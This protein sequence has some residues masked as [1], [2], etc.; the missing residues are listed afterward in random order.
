MKKILI[1]GAG[2][3]GKKVVD[4]NLLYS[5]TNQILAIIDNNPRLT[6]YNGIAI[7]SPQEISNYVYDEIWICT[8]YYEEIREQLIK[9]HGVNEEMIVYIE[10]VIHIL[11]ERI[12]EK[13]GN[14]KNCDI[15]EEL[16]SVV[17]Y[18][19]KNHA[20]MYCYPFYDEYIHNNP[21]VVFDKDKGMYYTLYKSKKMYFSKRL[22]TEQKVKTYFNSIVMEQDAKSPHCYWHNCMKAEMGVYVD[23]GAAE[24]IFS[25]DIIEKAAHV[26]IIEVD[27][28]W[29]EALKCT[30]KPFEEKVTIVS[31]YISDTDGENYSKLD[32]VFEKEKIDYIK[33]DI[34]GMEFPALKGACELLHR[35]D[36]KM[37]ICVYHHKDD[38]SKINAWLLKHDYK[39]ENSKGY[40]L[41][42]GD[43][44]LELNE[45]DFR[46]GLLYAHKM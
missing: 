46:R 37:A 27:E 42:Q 5:K 30:F 2:E 35:C 38:N 10:P 20:H 43:W 9:E 12:R 3:R 21:M 40:V 13:Y 1:F 26:Y 19:N 25:L 18:V 36:V 6:C 23:V 29:I 15:S 14:I 34:E 45:T 32:T 31:T 7:I 41:C 4:E 39:T 17:D 44:E 28:D 16:A 22:D 33:M 11:E 24:G 8:I